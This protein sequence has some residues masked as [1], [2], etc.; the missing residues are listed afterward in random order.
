[1]AK[2]TIFEWREPFAVELWIASADSSMTSSPASAS[3][4]YAVGKLL[5]SFLDRRNRCRIVNSLAAV[6]RSVEAYLFGSSGTPRGYDGHIVGG[7]QPSNWGE[8]ACGLSASGKLGRLGPPS[9]GAVKHP[10]AT[11]TPE[12]P[13]LS[14]PSVN[15]CV[16]LR[17]LFLHL[18]S[19]AIELE[20]K[21]IS[22]H[23][24]LFLVEHSQANGEDTIDFFETCHQVF[25]LSHH[26]LLD[27]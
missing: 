22:R 20:F 23:L 10:R 11:K 3:E 7:P 25:E 15:E 6:S 24:R 13:I 8:T 19:Q 12:Q 2:S 18:L 9:D 26:R 16:L 5:V 17:W 1:M 27:T 21:V 14:N 4:L